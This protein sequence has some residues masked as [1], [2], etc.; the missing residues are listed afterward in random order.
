M[1]AGT[2]QSV[3]GVHEQGMAP[4]QWENTTTCSTGQ[5][6]NCATGEFWHTLTDLSVPGRGVPLNFA[7]TYNS[8]NASVNGPLGYG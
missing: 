3:V 6:V 5:P 2:G 1:Q 7:R 4:N 8:I